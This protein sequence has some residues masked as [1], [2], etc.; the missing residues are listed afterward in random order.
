MA[1]HTLRMGGTPG[2][3][4]CSGSSSQPR[5]G[6]PQSRRLSPRPRGGPQPR[7]CAGSG[8][9]RRW[10]R[11]YCAPKREGGTGLG[12]KPKADAAGRR[13]GVPS[14][15]LS[16]TEGSR[17]TPPS[18]SRGSGLVFQNEVEMPGAQPT[19]GGPRPNLP[20]G[21]LQVLEDDRPV[22]AQHVRDTAGVQLHRGRRQSQQRQQECPEHGLR[23]HLEGLQ[24]RAGHPGPRGGAPSSGL[25]DHQLHP[26]P[27]PSPTSWGL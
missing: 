27:S 26:P 23:G 13:L 7:H 8:P 10:T 5:C 1:P 25:T 17:P 4:S 22:V 21:G 19:P 6:G 2:A 12:A 11:E 3:E 9:G 16:A 14:Y 15:L 18:G 20:H 24:V